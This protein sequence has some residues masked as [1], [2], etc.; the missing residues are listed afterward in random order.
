MWRRFFSKWNR[1]CGSALAFS[2]CL[3]KSELN[4][5]ACSNPAPPNFCQYTVETTAEQ[6]TS[7]GQDLSLW[8][9]MI[10]LTTLLTARSHETWVVMEES[11]CVLV[12]L[13]LPPSSPSV[14][15]L[16][17]DSKLGGWQISMGLPR[18]VV[19]FGIWV[20]STMFEDCRQFV[21]MG[22][23]SLGGVFWW[24]RGG[25]KVCRKGAAALLTYNPF[26]NLSSSEGEEKWEETAKES[27]T[28]EE[29]KTRQGE[30]QN[31]TEQTERSII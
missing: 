16:S 2:L 18:L 22:F 21:L 24:W 13:F 15:R 12:S 7:R 19:E 11:V 5:R 25:S 8:N 23:R 20:Y 6:A 3:M 29:I 14:L 4:L 30:D 9:R 26:N 27:N 10:S 17:L 31:T 1:K 28:E